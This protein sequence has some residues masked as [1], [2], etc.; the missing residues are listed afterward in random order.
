MLVEPKISSIEEGVFNFDGIFA[1]K[2][3]LGFNLAT[4]CFAERMT[5]EEQFLWPEL[6]D[7]KYHA[8]GVADNI[9]QIREYYADLIKSEEH[10]IIITAALVMKSEEEENGWRWHK[11]GEYIGTKEPK[12]E[13]LYDEDDSISEVFVFHCYLLG[14]KKEEKV[15]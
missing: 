6:F 5:Y 14:Y 8:Y 3:F 2:G 13:Y 1:A 9:E 4:F 15:L 10:K 7:Y 12:C 11:W